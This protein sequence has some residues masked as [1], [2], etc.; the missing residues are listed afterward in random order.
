MAVAVRNGFADAA[1]GDLYPFEDKWVEL[2]DGHRMHYIEAGRAGRR[3][4]TFLLLHGNPTWSFLY[5]RFM[6]PL[7]RLGRV[8]AV[9]HMGFGR[10][11]HPE[12]PAYYTLER[13]IQNLE[14][15]AAATHLRRVVPVV[16]DWGGPIGLG[17]ATRHPE[18]LAGLVVMN[19]WAFTRRE[20]VRVP[21]W[22]KAMRARGVG[23]ALYKR[24]NLFVDLM[25]PKTTVSKIPPN[26]MAAYRHPFP[27]PRS[28][29]GI[30]AFPRMIPDTP[31][32]PDWPTMDA[33][34]RAL[35]ELDVPAQILWARRD[36][37][38]APRFAHAFHDILPDAAP[39]D[40]FEGAGHYLQ[41]D[42]PEE[43][44]SRIT[45]FFS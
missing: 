30:L 37:A 28:R 22:F 29:A 41:E 45:R 23:E 25:I 18:D 17:Y 14:A 11:D 10:S 3:D 38:F 9:D 26:V 36:P 27:T 42:I 15:F 40:W 32:H 39:P 5:R 13:H 35:P 21:T 8:V 6:E 31:H 34:E 33:I 19:T 16:Q 24:R 43:L 1:L 44:V 12:D 7:S 2:P 20:P 4:L